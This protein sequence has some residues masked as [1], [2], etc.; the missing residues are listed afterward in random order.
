MGTRLPTLLMAALGAASLAAQQPSEPFRVEVNYVEIDAVVTDREN[1]FVSNLRKEDFVILE[2]GTRQAVATFNAIDQPSR[3]AARS[4]PASPPVE[5]DVF[6]NTQ[7]LTAGRP[8]RAR[9]SA[10]QPCA[11][12]RQD[13]RT[14]VRRT[15]PPMGSR[16]GRPWMA[17]SGCRT[18]RRADAARPCDRQ[19]AGR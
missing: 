4:R 5:P 16:G 1:R 6:T 14:A 13:L 10:H 7:P 3:P 8:A 9:R 17:R 2:D 18:S 19:F 15:A 11:E 12:P